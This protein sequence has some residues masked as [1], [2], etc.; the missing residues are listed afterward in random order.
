MTKN[1][2]KES[3]HWSLGTLVFWLGTFE[4]LSAHKAPSRAL[5]QGTPNAYRRVDRKMLR[6]AILPDLGFQTQYG[7]MS[8]QHCL[9]PPKFGM[10]IPKSERDPCKTR[11]PE[12]D[13]ARR[14]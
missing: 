9:C 3:R 12:L 2:E 4:T 5:V 11:L 7:C 8:P 1:D 14:T 6:R 10:K 13:R